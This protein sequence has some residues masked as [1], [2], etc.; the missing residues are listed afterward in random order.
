MKDVF[1]V[2]VVIIQAGDIIGRAV[3]LSKSDYAS[4]ANEQIVNLCFGV[5]VVLL[6]GLAMAS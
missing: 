3:R 1:I 5:L 4:N 2:V 6:G